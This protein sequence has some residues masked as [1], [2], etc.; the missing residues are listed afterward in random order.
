[1]LAAN[2]GEKYNQTTSYTLPSGYTACAIARF[3]LSGSGYTRCHISQLEV[4]GANII[5][6]VR[7]DSSTATGSLTLKVVVFCLA[8]V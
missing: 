1:M 3:S 5:W 6:S 7:N 4:D 2:G 8:T